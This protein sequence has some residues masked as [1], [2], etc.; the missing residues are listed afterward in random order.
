MTDAVGNHLSNNVHLPFTTQAPVALTITG[1]GSSSSPFVVATGRYSTVAISSS[2]VVFDGLVAADS[3]SITSSSALSHYGAT[4]TTVSKLYVQTNSLSIDGTSKID[5]SGK[6][7]LGGWQGSNSSDS[8][9]TNDNTTSGGST[10]TNGASYG[11]L[12]GMTNTSSTVNSAYGDIYDPNQFGSGGGGGYSSYYK[13]YFH[14]GNGGGMVRLKTTGTLTLNGSILANGMA[15]NDYFAGG[16]GSGGGIRIDVGTLAGIG[17][18][19]AK[20]GESKYDDNYN[21][22]HWGNGGGGGGRIAIYY[23]SMTLPAGS[24]GRPLQKL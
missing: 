9:R 5:V 8:G 10:A 19:S 7:Y 1:R 17:S 11:G 14:G 2:Y 3:I 6:G 4:T 12:G 16:G 18:I 13:S 22:Y 20:G 21:N 24:T 23:D 15:S